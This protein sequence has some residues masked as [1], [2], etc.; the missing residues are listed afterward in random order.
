MLQTS[1]VQIHREFGVSHPDASRGSDGFPLIYFPASKTKKE[2]HQI[3]LH[4]ED[5][6]RRC[7]AEVYAPHAIQHIA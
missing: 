5:L 3:Y 1:L 6:L 4:S 2:I 7:L